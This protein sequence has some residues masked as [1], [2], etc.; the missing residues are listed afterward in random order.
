M[1]NQQ[2]YDRLENTM[3]YGS[4]TSSKSARL[5]P[6]EPVVMMRGKGCRVWDAEGREFIDFKNGL[7]PVTL[8]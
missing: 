4:S 8:G 5:L 3:P 1:T 2:W 7:G 6:E